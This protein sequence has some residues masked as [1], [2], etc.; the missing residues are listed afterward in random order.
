[1]RFLSFT[2]VFLFAATQALALPIKTVILD[3]PSELVQLRVMVRAGSAHDAAGLE[4][5]AALTGR[6]LIEGS[7]GDPAAPVTKEMLAEI[8][9]P[10]GE[11]ASP[12]VLVEKETSTFSFTVPWEVFPEFAARVLKPLFNQPLFDG[13]ELERIQKETALMITSTLRQENTELLGLYALDNFVHE[14]TPYGHLPVGTIK[15]LLAAT[16]DDVRRFY[17]THYKPGNVT[18]GISTADPEIRR[19]VEGSLKTMGRAVK[20]KKLHTPRPR[21]VSA[22]EGRQVLIVSQPATIATGIH[23]GFPIAVNRDHPD[24]WALY[25]AN[26]ALGTHRDSFG[27]LYREIRQARGHNYGDYSYVE[28]FQHRPFYLFPPPNTPRKEQYFSMWVR[29]VAHEYAHHLLKAIIWELENLIREGLTPGE[30]ELA[31]NKAKVLYLSLA[32][33]AERLLAYKLDDNFYGLREGYLDSY[34]MAI[35]EVTPEQV[36]SAIQRHLQTSNMKIVLITSEEW[37]E[38]LA[39]DLA[40]NEDAKG[41]DLAAYNFEA[42]EVEG[43]LVYQIPEEK[44]AMILKDK[45]WEAYLLN[46]SAERIRVVKSIQLF[47]SSLLI[48]P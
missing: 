43:K 37:A 3:S 1:M 44:K 46:V 21:K 29:P 38:R 35:N 22:V 23:A 28:W 16:G 20:A 12:S 47:E 48:E 9:R 6:M 2:T 11:A 45:L 30:V 13:E 25:V 8:T 18:V 40:S 5:L 31:K 10:W 42:A 39:E 14:G 4:G 34:L 33:T 17:K 15:G 7:F 32:E 26:V 27:R 24:Y 41:K 19:L 36:N